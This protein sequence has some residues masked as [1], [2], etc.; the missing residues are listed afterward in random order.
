LLTLLAFLMFAQTACHGL[1][2]ESHDDIAVEVHALFLDT[3][4]SPVVVLKEKAGTRHLKIWIGPGEARSIAR[5]IDDQ[6]AQ[7]PNSHDLTKE[8]IEELEGEVKSVVVTELRGGTY[9]A[10]LFLHVNGDVTEVD[11]RPSD[12]IA[13]ALRTRAPIFVRAILFRL[14]A[15]VLDPAVP[16]QAI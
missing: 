1:G 12:A 8:I 6:Q 2:P 3:H 15:E 5:A 13:I 7:R 16:G 10:T 14:S 4:H 11:S 9:Y